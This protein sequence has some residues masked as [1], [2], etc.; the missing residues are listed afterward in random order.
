[1]SLQQAMVDFMRLS[2][3]EMLLRYVDPSSVKGGRVP[4]DVRLRLA[5][6]QTEWMQKTSHPADI[7]DSSSVA[8]LIHAISR[9]IGVGATDDVHV[10]HKDAVG[11]T[12]LALR[13]VITSMF[14]TEILSRRN[15]QQ[16][17]RPFFRCLTVDT[18]LIKEY[19]HWIADSPLLAQNLID[20]VFTG[21]IQL[22]QALP[23]LADITVFTVVSQC[24]ALLP[25]VCSRLCRD[26]WLETMGPVFLGQTNNC[27]MWDNA[28]YSFLAASFAQ[29]MGI[30]KSKGDPTYQEVSCY[31]Q[32]GSNL[33][34]LC[35]I[36]L[37]SDEENRAHLWR[38][39]PLIDPTLW[40]SCLEALDAFIADGNTF[41][42][43]ELLLWYSA[44][45]PDGRPLK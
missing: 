33:L 39:V 2:V 17:L 8:H 10:R 45:Y 35:Q 36:L 1:M 3:C 4:S 22:P 23:L 27:Y 18:S 15:Q 12:F 43:I 29:S 38:L 7:E 21:P 20:I 26:E 42:I 32:Q 9:S 14:T 37:L 19:Q 25:M 11:A 40:P 34:I 5:L 44:S 16:L 41:G 6:I 13:N 31:M 24:T 30:L 28:A